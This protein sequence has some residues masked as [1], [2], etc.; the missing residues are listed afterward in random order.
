M[1]RR[2]VCTAL[3]CF[4]AIALAP[5][6][7]TAANAVFKGVYFQPP[8]SGAT[9]IPHQG[10]SGS[11]QTLNTPQ[12]NYHSLIPSNVSN[13][14]ITLGAQPQLTIGSDKY[15]LS[16]ANI[17]GGEEGGAVVQADASGLLTT[18]IRVQVGTAD[19]NVTYVYF[20]AG[21]PCVPSNASN[22][23][24]NGSAAI[25]G[26][27]G[28][29]NGAVRYD[30]F[31]TV[32]SPDTSTAENAALTKTGNDLG[33]VATSGAGVQQTVRINADS[34]PLSV[35]ANNAQGAPITDLTFDRWEFGPGGKIGASSR[36]LDVPEG[37]GLYALALY[38]SACPAG[39]HWNATSAV[40]QCVA[41]VCASDQYWNSAEN[42]CV[43]SSS[44]ATGQTCVVYKC[45]AQCPNSCLVVP[46]GVPPNQTGTQPIFHCDTVD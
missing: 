9:R 26:E 23:T 2:F 3:I 35:G 20:P 40:S 13:Y 21:S 12:F 11:F 46:P 8:A 25:I 43:S 10:A 44:C 7:A 34:P 38:R 37:K 18:H 22:C 1:K 16:Y 6:P 31:V 19:I 15:I 45:P 14:P 42:K 36:D 5:L 33:V 32:F 17:T 41:N 29:A 30:Y 28:E 4:L 24:S 27:V 39:Y